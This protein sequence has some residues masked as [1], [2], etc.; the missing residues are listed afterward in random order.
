LGLITESIPCRNP[1]S[2]RKCTAL[3][4]KILSYQNKICD[5]FAALF[6]IHDFC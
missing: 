1:I 4:S 3:S 6:L 5:T 2:T